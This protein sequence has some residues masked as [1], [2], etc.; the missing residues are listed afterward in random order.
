MAVENQIERLRVKLLYEQGLM[1]Q[2]AGLLNIVTFALVIR[3]VVSRAHIVSW[4]TCGLA[5]FLARIS[6]QA[7]FKRRFL[8]TNRTF[9]PSLWENIFCL[10]VLVSGTYWA[11]AATVLLSS[12][13]V[14]YQTF[15]AFMLAGVTAGATVGYS[16]SMKAV[17]S[18]VIPALIPYAIVLMIGGTEI[19]QAMAAMI[20]LY[21]ITVCVVLV[22]VNA[23]VVS[24]IRLG[25][26]KDFLMDKLQTSQAEAI[27][28]QKMAAIGM[29]AGGV[30]HEINTPLSTIN[31]R[32]EEMLQVGESER[33]AA[34]REISQTVVR[35]SKI[36]N[37]LRTFSRT[38]VKPQHKRV[39]IAR[40]V[41]DTVNLCRGQ[42]EQYG[43]SVVVQDG[44]A[45]L[46]FF[47]DAQQVGQALLNLL[48]NS[49]EALKGAPDAWVTVR[50]EF[51][52]THIRLM[53]MDNGRGIP[54]E[55]GHE[56]TQL[57]LKENGGE[58]TSDSAGQW[59]TFVIT[60]PRLP[61]DSAKVG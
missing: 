59:T 52:D 41:A 11:V 40:V 9:D 35:I 44:P 22:R 1:T 31:L 16:S 34:A 47:G 55:F 51:D 54:K 23:Y 46:E 25:F 3:N 36:V 58:V 17:T 10:S 13:M 19:Q 27:R 20:V 14:V 49:F 26:E 2:A 60:L 29:L 28:S 48:T 32:V 30:A 18:F 8:R 6:V 43:I 45:D 37:S 53:V 12:D 50:T 24:S 39:E 42:F 5:L 21:T 38:S 61:A 33:E 56:M 57:I 7:F 4:A 15:L